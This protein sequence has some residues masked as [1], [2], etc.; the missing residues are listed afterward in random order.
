MTRKKFANQGTIAQKPAKG[1][2]QSILLFL[3]PLISC[4]LRAG[5]EDIHSTWVSVE[6][7][8][9]FLQQHTPQ[10]ET[11]EKAFY[12]LMPGANRGWFHQDPWLLHWT[13]QEQAHWLSF[14][15]SL[16]LFSVAQYGESERPPFIESPIK[17]LN[18]LAQETLST[19]NTIGQN[20][21]RRYLITLSYSGLLSPL[22]RPFFDCVLDT[23]PMVDAESL[24]PDFHRYRRWL[25]MSFVGNPWLK[26][27]WIR[28]HLDQFY[29]R[30]W[31]PR[32]KQWIEEYK[33]PRFHE[34]AMVQ[35]Y[36]I[37]SRLIEDQSWSRLHKTQRPSPRSFYFLALAEKENP[38]LL[39]AQLEEVSKIWSKPHP[40]TLIHWVKEATHA[41]PSSQP[42]IY[43]KLL[44]NMDQLCQKDTSLAQTPQVWLWDPQQPESPEVLQGAHA[45]DW[46]QDRLRQTR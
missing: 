6:G 24:Y 39:K 19:S 10:P 25:E 45:R 46:L 21:S 3:A 16:Q 29:L 18:S 43:Q 11:P 31:Q 15:W 33:L 2:F 5:L 32:V 34:S 20:Y 22:L 23:A 38:A 9:V 40:K 26:E 41:I 17:S 27:L 44:K 28:P 30:H 7:R 35:G 37:L 14:H 1:I 36:V 8:K 42:L 13:E 4:P 12:Y